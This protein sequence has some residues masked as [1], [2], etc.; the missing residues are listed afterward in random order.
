M[1]YIKFQ[2]QTY[3]EKAA[4]LLRT[5][6]FA[7]RVRRN[8]NPNRSEGCNF[9]VFVNGNIENAFELVSK[10]GIPNLGVEEFGDK[11]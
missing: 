6:G 11:R 7:V 8:P 9:A 1:K 3:A 4:S 10:N 2:T 5:K